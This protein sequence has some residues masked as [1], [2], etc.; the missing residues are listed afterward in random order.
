[1]TVHPV[2]MEKWE[3]YS[4]LDEDEED[5][6]DFYGDYDD[7]V[8]THCT[9]VLKADVGSYQ[10]ESYALVTDDSGRWGWTSYSWGSCS[11]CDWLQGCSTK[12]EVEEIRVAI[13]QAIKWFDSSQECLDHFLT[14]NWDDD[15]GFNPEYGEPEA[16]E[17]VQDCIKFL[18]LKHG[19]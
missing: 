2:V 10:G 3:R 12:E 18:R 14:R 17:W 1:M 9:I 6:G 11:G 8:E 15:Y 4:W 16:R 7:L 19:A 13:G 5:R